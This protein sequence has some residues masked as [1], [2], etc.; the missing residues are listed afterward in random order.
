MSDKKEKKHI[1][2]F[3]M[4]KSSNKLLIGVTLLVGLIFLGL[5]GYVTYIN[6]FSGSE[7]DY[8]EPSYDPYRYQ[9]YQEDYQYYD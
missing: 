2:H 9:G 1:E 3:E 8:D 6:F 7:D 4:P 5:I